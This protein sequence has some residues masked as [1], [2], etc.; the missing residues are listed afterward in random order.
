LTSIVSV[1]YVFFVA[2]RHAGENSM[3][4]GA[5]IDD[6]LERRGALQQEAEDLTALTVS[7]D[8]DMTEEEDKDF[9]AKIAE[10]KSLDKRR[11]RLEE[12]EKLDPVPQR[13]TQPE[14]IMQPGDP[15][16]GPKE[17]AK[18][19]TDQIRSIEIP[20]SCRRGTLTSFTRERFGDDH[21]KRA[22][23]FGRAIFAHLGHALSQRWCHDHGIEIRVHTE[24]VNWQGGVLVLDQFDNDLIRLVEEYGVF[25]RL[26]RNVPMTSD[27]MVRDRRTGGLTAYAVG[28]D[29]A[30]TESTMSF[31]QITLVAKKWMVLAT[32]S[33]ELNE[34]A[35]ISMADQLMTE[36]AYAFAKK[37]DDCGFLGDGTST[38]HGITGVIKA[39]Q[40]LTATFANIAGMVVGAGADLS[41][42]TLANL[43]DVVGKLPSYADGAPGTSWFCHKFVYNTV[44]QRLAY[45]AGG[46]ATGDIMSGTAPTFMGYP[47]TFVQSMTKVDAV[48]QIPIILGNLA[49]AADFGDRRGT[50]VSF[51]DVAYVNSKSMFERD[52]IAVKATTRYDINVHD[53]GNQTATAADKQAGPLVCFQTA[54]A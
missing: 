54:A 12:M 10:I 20:E 43:N 25:R 48:S 27:V 9:T 14:P 8:R 31:D 6:L 46:N 28:E 40:N 23:R 2:P 53:V 21:E 38:Y 22:Y 36:I 4:V 19:G 41:E 26:A 39:F 37:E 15:T 52:S 29:D 50:T 42:I 51:S 3:P 5:T 13:R 34:D 30:G 32:M 7:E 49:M 16:P 17:P 44:L 33:S 1:A 24:A 11:E 45:A 35:I 18:T 47:V